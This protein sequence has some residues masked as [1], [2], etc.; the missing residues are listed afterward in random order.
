ML[1]LCGFNPATAPE[2]SLAK[3]STMLG[4]IS[5]LEAIVTVT[6]AVGTSDTPP[7]RLRVVGLIMTEACLTWGELAI[8]LAI[9]FPFA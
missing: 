8:I 5:M 2:T 9:S 6:D 4:V 7:K 3:L 1:T